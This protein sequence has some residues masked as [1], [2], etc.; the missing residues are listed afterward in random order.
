MFHWNEAN[1]NHLASHG[2]TASEAEEVILNKP[3][4]IEL[5]LRNGET[6]ILHLGETNVGRVL[7]VVTTMRDDRVRVV[8]AY[9][10]NRQMR[11]FWMAHKDSE[12]DQTNADP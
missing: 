1:R 11:K 4:D 2:V 6:R 8:T 9:P 12:D 3:V 10:A 5:Q 7:V